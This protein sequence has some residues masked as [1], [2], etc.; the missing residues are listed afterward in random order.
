MRLSI[1]LGPAG[2]LFQWS[3]D[4]GVR[5]PL[6]DM[7]ILE[8]LRELQSSQRRPGFT[9]TDVRDNSQFQY[10]HTIEVHRVVFHL[11][12]RRRRTEIVLLSYQLPVRLPAIG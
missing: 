12:R 9:P 3:G 7:A 2:A 6:S 11:P 4:R 10:P 1:A 5:L 8:T